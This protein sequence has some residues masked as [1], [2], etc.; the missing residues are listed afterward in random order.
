MI[1]SI[2]VFYIVL[3]LPLAP[4]TKISAFEAEILRGGP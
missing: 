1:S 3:D 2:E 4:T